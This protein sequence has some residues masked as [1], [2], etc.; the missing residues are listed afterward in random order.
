MNIDAVSN[1]SN[2]YAQSLIN[3]TTQGAN[4]TAPSSFST[5]QDGAPQLSPLAQIMSQLQQIQQQNPTEYSQ[6]TQQIA[7]NLQTAAQ[8]AQA[9]GNPTQANQLTQL[10]TVFQNDSQSGQLPSFQQLQQASGGHHH[11]H[12]HWSGSSDD[13]GASSNTTSSATPSTSSASP[14]LSQLFTSSESNSAE[15]ESL[16]PFSIILSTLSSAGSSGSGN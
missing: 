15:N 8:T 2:T 13:S 5:P 3:S 16:N 10:A 6:V 1:L 9:D 4:G 11:H 12:H 7:T 14:S